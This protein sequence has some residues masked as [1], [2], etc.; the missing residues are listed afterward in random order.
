MCEPSYD[1]GPRSRSWVEEEGKVFRKGKVL[2]GPDEIE[3]EYA[4]EHIRKEVSILLASW[5]VQFS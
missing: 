3:G 5:S 4:N 1:I 2:L